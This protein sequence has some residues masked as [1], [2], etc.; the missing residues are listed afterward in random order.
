MVANEQPCKCVPYLWWTLQ[1]T[2]GDPLPPGL[3]QKDKVAVQVHK[4][5]LVSRQLNQGPPSLV[6]TDTAKVI[7]NGGQTS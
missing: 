2:L 3:Q 5:I 6:A 1:D 4:N 7:Y